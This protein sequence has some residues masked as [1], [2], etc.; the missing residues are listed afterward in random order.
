VIAD[1]PGVGQRGGVCDQGALAVH[2]PGLCR[3]HGAPEVERHVVEADNLAV[4][5]VTGAGPVPGSWG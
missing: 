5:A 2:D 3:G 4:T 1:A